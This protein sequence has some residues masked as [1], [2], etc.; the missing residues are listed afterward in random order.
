M[1]LPNFAKAFPTLRDCDAFVGNHRDIF[2]VV[3]PQQRFVGEALKVNRAAT[4]VGQK[5]LRET[6]SAREAGKPKRSL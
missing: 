3:V 6:L 1:F 4:D 5:A 2:V